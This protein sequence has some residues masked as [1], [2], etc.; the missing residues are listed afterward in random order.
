[1]KP[2]KS[3]DLTSSLVDGL[4]SGSI[5][6]TVNSMMNYGEEQENVELFLFKPSEK[7]E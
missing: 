4:P 6:G 5:G 2:S 7:V 3:V 1:L